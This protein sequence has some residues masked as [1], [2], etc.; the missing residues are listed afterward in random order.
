MNQARRFGNVCGLL[1]YMAFKAG[2]MKSPDSVE[3]NA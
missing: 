3:A 1:G 2:R